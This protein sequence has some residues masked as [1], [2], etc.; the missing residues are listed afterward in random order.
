MREQGTVAAGGRVQ[1]AKRQRRVGQQQ[2]VRTIG[3]DLPDPCRLSRRGVHAP[4]Q[5]GHLVDHDDRLDRR[6][7]HV[8]AGGTELAQVGSPAQQHKQP[9][10]RLTFLEEHGPGRQLTDL[11]EA[12]RG[13]QIRRGEASEGLNVREVRNQVVHASVRPSALGRRGYARLRPSLIRLVLIGSFIILG[14]RGVYSPPGA[15][16]DGRAGRQ[17]R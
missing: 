5:P 2:G 10:P 8:L 7:D 11:A 15:G 4:V 3:V 9:G 12:D 1:E 13:P 14:M 6:Q 16:L 17:T